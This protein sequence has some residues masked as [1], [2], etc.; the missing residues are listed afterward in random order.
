MAKLGESVGMRLLISE[1]KGA[2]EIRK[3]RASFPD[4][5]KQSD[6][7]SVHAPLTAETRGMFGCAEFELMKPSALLINTAR[8]GL[9]QDEAL[10]EAL[11]EGKIAGAGVD[12]LNSEPP[13][14]QHPLLDLKL[15]NLIV[16][17][18]VA[19]ASNEAMQALAD[20]VIDNLE[21]FV[22]GQPQNLLT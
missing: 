9:I 22:R 7:V 2:S 17:P 14:Q 4:V 5:L 15:P 19:W 16:T 6:I 20:Q 18:H 11:R 12:A 21:A 10:I 3:G 8:G 1:H 13:P